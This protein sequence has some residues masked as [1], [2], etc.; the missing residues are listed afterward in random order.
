MRCE[1]LEFF[2]GPVS[3]VVMSD[4][5]VVLIVFA[6][7]ADDFDRLVLMIFEANGIEAHGEE[8]ESN[9]SENFHCKNQM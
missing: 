2:V 8:E 3:G 1:P 6:S 5:I 9:E 7:L 4:S